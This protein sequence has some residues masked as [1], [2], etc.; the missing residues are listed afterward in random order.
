MKIKCT[1]ST[2]G[3]AIEE[4]DRYKK[5]LEKNADEVKRLTAESCRDFASEKFDSAIYDGT[6]DVTV[7]VESEN[8]YLYVVAHGYAVAFIEF[9]TGIRYPY[10][11]PVSVEDIGLDGRGE[12][13]HKLGG[14]KNGWRYPAYNGAGTNGVTDDE[15]PGYIKTF[16]NPSNR[17]LYDAA[18]EARYKIPETA[19]EVFGR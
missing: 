19:K 6:N 8:E 15:H 13:G 5:K 14:L 2:I 10:T 18:E 3:R 16:G 11:H 1:L 4:L 12:F 17:C 7:V 9:G